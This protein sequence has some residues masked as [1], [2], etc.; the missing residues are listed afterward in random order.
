MNEELTNDEQLK[1]AVIGM[2]I[3]I[4][5]VFLFMGIVNTTDFTFIPEADAQ[6]QPFELQLDQIR[7]PQEC[8]TKIY[9]GDLATIPFVFKVFYDTT[10]DRKFEVKQHANTFPVTQ[11][12]PQVMTFYSAEIDQ[13]EIYLEMN[14]DEAKPR[15]VYY[16]VLSENA[17]TF[18]NQEK[19]ETKKFCMRVQVF[20][21]E[22]EHIPTREE[23]WGDTLQ[24][25]EQIPA[26]LRAFNSNTQ[27]VS[28][29]IQYVILAIVAIVVMVVFIM[30]SIWNSKRIW[31]KKIEDFDDMIKS[32]SS[33]T[34][35][36]D[37]LVRSVTEPLQ[38]ILK[39][40]V[41]LM[42]KISPTDKSL[43]GIKEVKKPKKDEFPIKVEHKKSWKEILHLEK[44]NPED[45][46]FYEPKTNNSTSAVTVESSEDNDSDYDKD[47]SDFD[48]EPKD[49]DKSAESDAVLKILRDEN[50]EKKDDFENIVNLGTKEEPIEVPEKLVIDTEPE[51]IPMSNVTSEIMKAI[52]LEQDPD[53][54]TKKIAKTDFRKF[55]YEQLNDAFKWTQGFYDRNK[56]RGKTRTEDQ[57][58]IQESIY[59]EL[60]DRWEKKQKK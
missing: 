19:F 36:M 35:S 44:H 46:E 30:I 20:T 5:Y 47:E 32:G 53:D 21:K 37:N 6:V 12:S 57:R 52:D 43:E 33:M 8:T 26:F 60:I 17:L 14:Y 45:D 39:N 54:M 3:G 23:I 1:Y 18:S 28:Q 55:S 13:Y 56:R 25:V 10:S 59:Y 49:E 15:Q 24:H 31:N 4:V 22:P 42:K 2:M 50:P 40:Q 29:E 11:Q 7:N 9:Q 48:H 41:N 58:L 38:Q 27:T 16:E 51:A 34:K